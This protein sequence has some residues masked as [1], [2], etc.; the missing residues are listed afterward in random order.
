MNDRITEIKGSL[1]KR[2]CHPLLW[3]WSLGTLC[4]MGG[5]A[6]NSLLPETE[7]RSLE[8]EMLRLEVELLSHNSATLVLQDWCKS[9]GISVPSSLVAEPLEKSLKPPPKEVLAWLRATPETDIHHRRVALRCGPV[10]LSIADNWFRADALSPAMLN[11]LATTREPFGT[12][13]KPLGF[14]RQLLHLRPLWIP[15]RN[16]DVPTYP[17]PALLFEISAVLKNQAGDPFSVVIE[18]YTR[19][20]LPLGADPSKKSW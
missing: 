6:S 5:C 15:D 14:Q 20:V 4:L 8:T 17:L 2:R 1:R 19:D 3:L 13:V 12:V 10:V 9:H 7:H 18:R 16:L 11:T